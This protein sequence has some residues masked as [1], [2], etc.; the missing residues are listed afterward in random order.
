M[1][2]GTVDWVAEGMMSAD[3]IEL[4]ART[5]HDH[6][7]RYELPI[8]N[9]FFHGSHPLGWV[10]S[11]E[12][13]VDGVAIGLDDVEFVIRSQ[14]IPA[15]LMPTITDIWWQPRERAALRF[16]LAGPLDGGV[17]DVRCVFRVST[18][19]FTPEIDIADQYPTMTLELTAP[20]TLDRTGATR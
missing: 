18:F 14:A 16:R 15:P 2:I 12:L 20:L 7:Y 17:H 19:F 10:R 4:P 5:G 13:E 11:L 3:I 9:Q 6:P 1:P 8:R